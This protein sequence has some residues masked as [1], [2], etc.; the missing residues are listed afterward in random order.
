VAPTRSTA[1]GAHAHDILDELR[2]QDHEDRPVPEVD[3]VGD[4]AETAERLPRQR[5]AHHVALGLHR[6]EDHGRQ[7]DRQQQESAGVDPGGVV[8]C[9]PP[10][11]DEDGEPDG[12]DRGHDVARR[13]VA[14]VDALEQCAGEE[15]ADEQ[16]L[17]PGVGAEVHP[18]GI[19]GVVAHGHPD[20]RCHAQHAGEP[21]D[22]VERLADL[23]HGDERERPEQVPL[24]L[25]GQRPHVLEG[26][27]DQELV[28]VRD[29]VDDEVPVGEV[30]ERGDAVVA[31]GVELGGLGE[32]GGVD[33]HHADDEEQRGQQPP[34]AT[35]PEL[36][37]VD[38]ARVAPLDEQQT[39]DEESRKHEEG[40]DAEIAAGRERDVVAG[41]VQVVEHHHEHRRAAQAVERRLVRDASR[42]G[43]APAAAFQLDRLERRARR[44]GAHVGEDRARPMRRPIGE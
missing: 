34:G 3:A 1:G 43:A 8:G 9:E 2:A 42:A 29:V 27:G 37:Q 28:E 23:E 4:E 11:H 38:P 20:D 18:A 7:R 15:R 14:H 13:P 10:A 16:R 25:D 17:R 33:H 31:D 12:S 24:L 35:R 40:V 21:Q 30:E 6:G 26:R 19:V 5:G 22:G 41:D 44:R 32:E 36:L 39:G